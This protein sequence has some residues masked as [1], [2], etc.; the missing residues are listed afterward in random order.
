MGVTTM[1]FFERYLGIGRVEL[2]VL[3]LVMGAI[4]VMLALFHYFKNN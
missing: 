2:E 4:L 1:D 3:F